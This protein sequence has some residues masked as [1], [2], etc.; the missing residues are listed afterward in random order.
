MSSSSFPLSRVAAEISSINCWESLTCSICDFQVA[1][2]G[3][4]SSPAPFS[5]LEALGLQ[6]GSSSRRVRKVQA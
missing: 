4:S 1:R 6:F 5:E 3:N 2:A